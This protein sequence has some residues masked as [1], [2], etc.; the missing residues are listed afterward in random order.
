MGAYEHGLDDYEFKWDSDDLMKFL[1]TLKNSLI[2][3]IRGM[4]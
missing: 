3:I 1:R 4:Q 2:V